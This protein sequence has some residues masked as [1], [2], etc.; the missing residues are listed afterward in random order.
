MYILH[1]W[2]MRSPVHPHHEGRSDPPVDRHV[3]A[4]R[5]VGY[6]P[7]RNAI[8]DCVAIRAAGQ[9]CGGELFSGMFHTCDFLAESVGNSNLFGIERWPNVPLHL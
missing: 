2:L 5:G 8:P 6:G 3:M 1:T 9:G 4:A 7:W